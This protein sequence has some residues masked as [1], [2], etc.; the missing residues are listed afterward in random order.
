MALALEGLPL[1][2][3]GLELPGMDDW[4]FFLAAG[5]KS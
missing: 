4:S 3:S 2:A 1:A 5:V